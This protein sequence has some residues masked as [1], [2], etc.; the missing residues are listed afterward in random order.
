MMRSMRCFTPRRTETFLKNVSQLLLPL[1]FLI[2][3]LVLLTTSSSAIAGAANP[4][5]VAGI[6][7]YKSSDFESAASFFRQ[8]GLLRPASGTFQNL[9]L[10]EWH[11]N[12]IGRA[13]LAWEQALWLDPFNRAARNNLR[14][15]RKAAQVDAPDLAW[16]EVI[17]GWLPG[18]WW[19]WIIS[20]SLWLAVG[21]VVLPMVF[22]RPKAFW[23]QALAAFGLMLFLLSLPAQLGVHTR[24]NVGF[25]LDKGTPLRL[26]PTQEAQT[27]TQLA[28]GESVRWLRAR[29]NFIL[30]RTSRAN[31]WIERNKVGLLCEQSRK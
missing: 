3:G 12:R 4:S 15:A 31:G 13:V 22:R 26:T 1:F 16:Y 10:A 7:A 18:N 14:F 28:P 5:F 8:S 9:G 24:T 27:L 6:Q 11:N 29:G 23:H 30:V 19:S 25:I 20:S 17:S 21:A 2:C